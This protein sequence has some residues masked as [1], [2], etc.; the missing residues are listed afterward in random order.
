MELQLVALGGVVAVAAAGLHRPAARTRRRLLAEP[1]QRVGQVD[2]LQRRARRRQRLGHPVGGDVVVRLVGRLELQQLDAAGAPV[3]A[4]LDPGARAALVVRLQILVAGEPAIALQQAEAAQRLR[5]VEPEGSDES[6]GARI[7]QRPPDPLA[8]A[9]QDLQAVGVMHL[10]A[11]VAGARLVLAGQ[12]HAGQRRQSQRGDPAAQEQPRLHL[13]PGRA[14]GAAARRDVEAVGA[15]HARPDQARIQRH[16]RRV[17]RGLL[18]P[19]A[20]EAREFLAL[21]AGGVHRQAARRQAVLLAGAE[22][23]EIARAQEDDQLVAVVRAVQRGVQP[24][25][26]D[27]GRRARTGQRRQL[28]GIAAVVEG[29]GRHLQRLHPALR[30]DL[31]DLQRLREA[32]P[33]M[34]EHQLEGPVLPQRPIR[35]ETD[36]AV[37]VIAQVEQRAVAAGRRVAPGL[38]RQR[39]GLGRDLVEAEGQGSAGRTEGLGDDEQA[40]QDGPGLHAPP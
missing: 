6:A 11:E 40:A 22:R 34:E 37:V 3:A 35:A 5:P 19:E 36:V 27:L 32:P 10:G 33:G 8:A 26:R 14:F 24:K 18:E 16:A 39:A 13:H 2:R 38:Q 30:V 1:V 20:V 29:G 9:G 28:R 25:A 15:G 4:G 17:G 31:L 12:E 21:A 7:V 23:A